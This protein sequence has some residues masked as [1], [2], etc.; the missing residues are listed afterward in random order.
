MLVNLG[1]PSSSSSAPIATVANEAPSMQPIGV[2]RTAFAEKRAVPRQ[3][4][5]GNELQSF[6]EINPT[7]FN[8]P[9]HSLEG[10]CDFSHMWIIYHFHRN[11]S[12]FRAKVAPPR[13][14]GHR[15]GVFSTRS[16]HRPCPIGLSL[17]TI[18]KVERN[19]VYFKGT[20]MVDETPV[21]D[22]KPYIPKYDSPLENH[23]NPEELDNIR[24]PDW[25]TA[26]PS[27]EV[28]FSEAATKQVEELGIKQQAIIKL[29]ETDPRSVYLRTKYGSQIFT[30]Q[31]G[32]STVSC[33]FDDD[34]SK[35][36]VLKVGSE[37]TL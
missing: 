1:S 19:R 5:L 36:E 28:S 14:N 12:H 15:V 8:N 16:P 34:Q 7:C 11:E 25:V 37:T 35:V 4:A 17:V 23:I 33:K 29:L 20:D 27:L 21:F 10:L 2:I 18:E 30:F 6:V 32:T 26:A 3:S 31:L 22:I 13:L 24:V 9:E